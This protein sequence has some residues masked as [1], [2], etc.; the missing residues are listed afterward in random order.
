M[1]V[2]VVLGSIVTIASL[3]R[4]QISSLSSIWVPLSLFRV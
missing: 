4:V 2:V 1:V 3:S